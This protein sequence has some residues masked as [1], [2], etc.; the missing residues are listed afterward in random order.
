MPWAVLGTGNAADVAL[1]EHAEVILALDGD[2]AG[3]KASD[4]VA[5]TLVARGH[6]VRV[7]ALP[8][9]RDLNDLLAAP[10]KGSIG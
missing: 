9:G 2:C 10:A 5:A 1:P 3:R 4:V 6:R 7:A 8:D